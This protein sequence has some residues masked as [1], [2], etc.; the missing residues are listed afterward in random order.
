MEPGSGGWHVAL[1]P[2]SFVAGFEGENVTPSHETESFTDDTSSCSTPCRRPTR[3]APIRV[4]TDTATVRADLDG[5][6]IEAPSVKDYFRNI[7]QFCVDTNWGRKPPG[8]CRATGVFSR[9]IG[10]PGG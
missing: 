5:A 3:S 4:R 8:W 2:P 6:G 1:S 10:L 9:T 7:M